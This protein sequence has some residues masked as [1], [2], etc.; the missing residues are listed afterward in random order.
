MVRAVD[1]HSR[2]GFKYPLT[3]D[4]SWMTYD[5]CY[6][7]VD[8]LQKAITSA[9]EEIQKTKLI[10][11]F[12]TWRRRLENCIQQEDYFELIGSD[13]ANNICFYSWEV[14]QSGQLMDTL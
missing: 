9:T 6:D 14:D 3:G 10:Q 7:A 11:V 4:E 2:T 13:A 1:N 12:Q 8:K 5:L